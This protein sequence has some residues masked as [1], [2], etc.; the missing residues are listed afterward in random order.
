MPNYA[1]KDLSEGVTQSVENDIERICVEFNIQFNSN[2][3]ENLLSLMKNVCLSTRVSREDSLVLVSSVYINNTE[4]KDRVIIITND[5]D[6]HNWVDESTKE[7]ETSFVTVG[8]NMPKVE[9]I[10]SMGKIVPHLEEQRNLT[11]SMESVTDFAIRYVTRVFMDTYSDPYYIGRIVR[12]EG[13]N[14]P[15]HTVYI[16]ISAPKLEKS[17]YTVVLSKNLSFLYCPQK[18]ALFWHNNKP[19]T[20]A[21]VPGKESIVSFVIGDKGIEDVFDMVNSEG[22]LVFVHPDSIDEAIR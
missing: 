4:I 22:N 14:A 8:L 15:E 17:L 11:D 7:L 16:K 1:Y 9:H 21:F 10:S 2:F 12:F 18:P 13:L 20:E 19:L 3:N 6:F 5:H